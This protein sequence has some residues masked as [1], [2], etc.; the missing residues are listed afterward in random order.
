VP[1]SNPV[2]RAAARQSARR[3]FRTVAIL[4]LLAACSYGARRAI[5]G[6]APAYVHIRWAA[7]VDETTRQQLER[8]FSLTDGVFRESRTF[9]YYLRDLSRANV[10]TLLAEPSVEDT[11]FIDRQTYRTLRK[12]LRVPYRGPGAPWIPR[13]LEVLSF[14]CAAAAVVAFALALAAYLLPAAPRPRFS[15]LTSA[16]TDPRRIERSRQALLAV[17]FLSALVR[18]EL[19]ERGGQ[20]YWTDERRYS[21]AQAILAALEGGR[22][23]D[24]LSL[25]DTADHLLF[26]IIAV[27]P[28]ALQQA[29]GDEGRSA[30]VFLSLFSVLSIALVWSISLRAGGSESEALFAA[31]LMAASS[32]FFYYSRHLVPYDVAMTLGLVAV[33]V[34]IPRSRGVSRS[35]MC[36][37]L[38][39]CTFL[40]YAGY[41]TLAGAA[42]L[43]HVAIPPWTGARAALRRAAGAT[44]GLAIPP[45]TVLAVSTALGGHL[46]E[47]FGSFA[48][49]VHDGTFTE[50]WRLPFE[51]LWHAEHG[52]LLLWAGGVGW[53]VWRARRYLTP[54]VCVG[55]L[56]LGVIY[57][58]FVATS[59]WL[60][61]F[62]VY[63]RLARQLVPFLCII[64]AHSLEQL[65][66][67]GTRARWI[68]WGLVSAAALQG[69]LNFQQPLRQQ[70][71]DEFREQ[72]E[73]LVPGLARGRYA[74]VY[75]API[76]P[77]P[78]PIHLPPHRTVATAAHPLQYLPYQYE[79]YTP[80]QRARLRA[81]DISMQLV[82]F[83]DTPR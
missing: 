33:L 65:R 82:V 59:T 80:E 51:Y 63:G 54:Q 53:A 45:V 39:G 66:T 42:V 10:R 57:G 28:A 6:P 43:I 34:G 4:C 48:G 31:I 36:G 24:A 73:L 62:V 55:L 60:E 74:F 12:A 35:L 5:Y 67:S 22:V 79:G 75:A 40:T 25:L 2:S 44:A 7:S 30:A 41:W 3:L 56:G 9:R 70:F 15:A 77:E 27:A 49:S 1:V 20:F 21:N 50:G 37:F 46:W 72:A 11:A 26:K 52:V 8:R 83:D 17:L 58:A 32:T 38:S 18:V 64:S 47:S 69:V 13:A 19:V 29:V 71:P 68:A 78:A 61:M 23:A 14:A 16:F 76:Y 81:T